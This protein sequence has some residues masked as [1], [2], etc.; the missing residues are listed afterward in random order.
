MIASVHE[1]TWPLVLSAGIVIA[2]RI[3]FALFGFR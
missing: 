2:G 3:A 1:V